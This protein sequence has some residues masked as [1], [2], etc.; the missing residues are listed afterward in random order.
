VRLG[1]AF[2]PFPHWYEKSQFECPAFASIG[3]SLGRTES[4]ERST[5]FTFGLSIIRKPRDG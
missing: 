5:S 2:L 3:H 4:G 1:L